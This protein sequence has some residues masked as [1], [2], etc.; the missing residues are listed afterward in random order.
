[1]QFPRSQEFL[2]PI[3]QCGIHSTDKL[4]VCLLYLLIGRIA[5]YRACGAEY[6]WKSRR[7]FHRQSFQLGRWRKE[8]GMLSLCPML[9]ALHHKFRDNYNADSSLGRCLPCICCRQ[10][11]RAHLLWVGVPKSR[12]K[13]G[14]V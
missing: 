13:R 5:G 8:R 11:A 4:R 14:S 12:H 6:L 10:P 1:M 9:S 3:P 2:L 7:S